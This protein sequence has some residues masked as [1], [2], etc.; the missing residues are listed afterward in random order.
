MQNKA[1]PTV[2]AEMIGCWRRRYIRYKNGDED[3]STRVLWL[4]TSSAAADMRIPA[5]RP[6]LSDRDALAACNYDELLALAAQDCSCVITTCDVD[7]KPYPTANWAPGGHGFTLQPVVNFPEPGW[8]QWCENNACMIEWAPSGA[9][10]EDWRVESAS[11]SFAAHLVLENA[12]SKT[13]LLVTDTHAVFARDRV[14]PIDAEVA[15]PILAELAKEDLDVVRALVDCEFSYTQ[16]DSADDDYIIRLSTLPW[17][18]GETL[19]L[20][21]LA[22]YKTGE[23]AL[24]AVDGNTW[25]VISWWEQA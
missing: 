15:L 8:F 5:D 1:A 7:A 9:Y 17:R 22:D 23:R 2:P 11:Q 20:S 10:E 25:Q 6:D 18:E 14:Q 13:C 4:Q 24:P 19:A 3:T 21:W 12:A 16:R